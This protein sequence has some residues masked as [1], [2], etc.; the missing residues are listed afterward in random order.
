[1]AADGQVNVN[2][3]ITAE[4]KGVKEAEQSL[5]S[6]GKKAR[7]SLKSM[8][9]GFADAERAAGMLNKAIG[10]LA[11][12]GFVAAGFNALVGLFDK[13]T[14]AHH[15]ATEQALALA[16]AEKDAADSARVEK[17]AEAYRKLQAGIADAAKARERANE[18]EDLQRSADDR[19]EDDTAELKMREEIA[20]LD[21]NDPLYDRKKERIAS[22]HEAEKL[23]RSV[24]RQQRDAGIAEERTW[25]ER[26]ATIG[27]STEKQ[28][29][30]MADREELA[31]LRREAAAKRAE[32]V[33]D[34][35]FDAQT[36]GQRFAQNLKAI[37]TL[38]GQRFWNDRTE[39]GDEHR[40][41]AESEARALD[42][43]VKAKE[44]EIEA[45][46]R[47]VADLDRAAAHLAKKAGIQGDIAVNAGVAVQAADVSSAT[48]NRA[49]EKSLAD[50]QA[51]TADAE[52]ARRLLAGQKADI[53][54]RIA[55][56]QAR[57]DAAG[58]AVYEAQGDYD[59]ARLGGSRRAQQSALGSLQAAQGAAQDVNHAADRAIG[60]LTE[61]LR[62]VEARLKAAQ[63]F[64]ES[65]SKQQRNAWAETPAGS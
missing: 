14:S 39:K 55:A 6:V 59:A 19:L 58:R 18:L 33:G 10:A 45:K 44:K 46:E 64:L 37:L 60:A 56:E 8:V 28:Y 23:R 42:E 53:Q 47:E 3:R 57:K 21:E 54:A 50:R 34:N 61:T 9:G 24:A 30:L 27:E 1:M 49:A 63:G 5:D 65:Q 13:V 35:A 2:L 51:K 31:R 12:F 38:D 16:A 41:K 25:Q 29:S 26:E 43:K 11:N 40:A 22:R 48:A 20:A 32:S 52:R 17:L 15:K 7:R 62:S 36:L 4:N